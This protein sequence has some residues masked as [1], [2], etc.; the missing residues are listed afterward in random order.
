MENYTALIVLVS[1]AI[2]LLDLF[3]DR[4][5]SL[6][7]QLFPIAL[8]G[9][10]TLFVIMYYFGPDIWTYVPHYE[11][12]GSFS[13]ELAFRHKNGFELGYNLFCSLMSSIGLSYWGMTVVIKTLY[14]IAIYLLLRQLPRR[15]MFSL[16]CI[17]LIDRDLI[18][19]E[20]REC[21]AV[22]LFIFMVLLLQ[23]RQ[24]L[25][26]VLCA[27]AAILTHKTA[28]LPIGILPFGIFF[29]R[30][31]QSAT[32]YTILIIL[33]M[34]IMLL[35]IQ[36]VSVS[37]LHL[38]PF[39]DVYIGALHHHLQLGRQ[40]Q[41]IALIYL[42]VLLLINIYIS[43]TGQQHYT[44]VAYVVLAGMAVVV[45]LYPYYFLLARIRS[46]FTPIVVFYVVKLVSD[47]EQTYHIPYANLVKQA[48]MVLILVYYLH[49]AI[50]LERFTHQ[51]HAPIARPCTIFELRNASPKQIR[52]RQMKIAY[53]YWQQDYMK[54][55]GNRL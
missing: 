34:V 41:L 43:R 25:W 51:L 50:K 39:P 6:Q 48:L 3:T 12:I 35:P 5:Q 44:W 27:A 8:L 42:G 10:Y 49:F 23:N 26:A 20:N 38:L 40:F 18:T 30:H 11:E 14:F 2:G 24:Y 29:Y 46:Y 9:I 53:Q 7:R 16:A 36:R 21:L 22:S 55:K 28:I 37:V 13:E 32:L 19:H 31:R 15:Q 1:I 54:E 4:W 17:V 45:V 33:L 52:D 47:S